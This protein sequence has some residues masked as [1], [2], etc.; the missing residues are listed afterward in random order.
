MKS[1]LCLCN[2]TILKKDLIR[3]APLM[4]LAGLVLWAMGLLLSE[5]YQYE[6]LTSIQLPAI[7][8]TIVAVGMGVGSAICL[9]TYLTKK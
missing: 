2:R 1:R 9:F 7:Y 8:G 5:F 3:F 4:L 6:E